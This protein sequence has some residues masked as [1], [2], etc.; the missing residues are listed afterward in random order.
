MYD[1][2]LGV[3]ANAESAVAWYRRAAESGNPL[4]EYNLADMYL[5]GKGVSQNDREAVQW[6]QKAAEQGHTGACI[7][8]AYMYAQG[9]GVKINLEYA[10][11]LVTEA[12][13]VGDA[14][15]RELIF[16]IEGQLSTEQRQN[17]K[18]RAASLHSA[19]PSLT[20]VTTLTP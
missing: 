5:E 3:A 17:A 14:R 7:K 2:G 1:S 8:L 6:F 19:F 18:A 13:F 4:G 15:G 10:Y 20:A 9:R 16:A 12:S 11:T